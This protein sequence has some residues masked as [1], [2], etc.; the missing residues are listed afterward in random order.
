MSLL[1]NCTRLNSDM[2]PAQ[3]IGSAE[4]LDLVK[5]VSTSFDIWVNNFKGISA[6]QISISFIRRMSNFLLQFNL[7]YDTIYSNIKTNKYF[8]RRNLYDRA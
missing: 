1:D 8:L 4:D 7:V 2:E 5:T 6:R 3:A